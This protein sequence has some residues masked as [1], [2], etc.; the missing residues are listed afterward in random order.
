MSADQKLNQFNGAVRECLER[1]YQSPDWLVAVAAYKERLRSDGW[2][3][4]DIQEV[5]RVVRRILRGIL[6][7]ETPAPFEGTPEFSRTDRLTA[8]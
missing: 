5:E 7:A 3:L 2:P 1:C 6:Y 4:E 8:S